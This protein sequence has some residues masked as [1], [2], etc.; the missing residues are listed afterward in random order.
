MH[1]LNFQI[2]FLKKK[3]KKS[4]FANSVNHINANFVEVVV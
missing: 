1:L 3:K 2:K 4:Q